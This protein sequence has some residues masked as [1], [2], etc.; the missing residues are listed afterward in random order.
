MIF[1]TVLYHSMLESFPCG[2]LDLLAK[3]ERCRRSS[4][5]R[6]ASGLEIGPTLDG[7]CASCR[8]LPL[9]CLQS[10]HCQP[11]ILRKLCVISFI[12]VSPRDI[13]FTTR[14]GIWL[15]CIGVGQH[16]YTY[17]YMY[18]HI[19]I[20]M[21]VYIW[22][23]IYTY[24]C[25]HMKHI[26]ICICTTNICTDGIFICYFTQIATYTCVCVVV[27]IHVDACAYMYASHVALHVCV[28]A[29]MHIL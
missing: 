21:H 19:Y 12:S 27:Y 29:C 10:N 18:I 24:L 14:T 5:F 9:K 22:V 4:S 28:H 16:T 3:A 7:K 1:A 6:V 23:C 13:C 20:Y 17:T 2:V 25:I 11:R 26:Y 15:K 8:S